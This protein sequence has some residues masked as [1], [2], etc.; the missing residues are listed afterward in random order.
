MDNV[1]ELYTRWSGIWEEYLRKINGN[2]PKQRQTKGVVTPPR[3][4]MATPFTSR[5]GLWHRK[6]ANFIVDLRKLRSMVATRFG[7]TTK[8]WNRV[9]RSSRAM[10]ERYGAPHLSEQHTE[11]PDELMMNILQESYDHYLNIWKAELRQK[12]HEKRVAFREQLAQHGGVNRLVSRLVKQSEVNYPVIKEGDNTISDPTEVVKRVQDAW[13]VYFNKKQEPLDEEWLE[14]QKQLVSNYP[15]QLPLLSAETLSDTIKQK[16]ASTSPGPDGWHMEEL[17]ALPLSSLEGLAYVLRRAEAQGR[18]PQAATDAWMA[19][20]PKGVE[21]SPPI[22]VRPITILSTVYR[23]YASTRAA[24]LQQWAQLAYHEWQYAFIKG[25]SARKQLSKLGL[26]LDEAVANNQPALAVSLDAS[27]AFPSIDR[28]QAAVLLSHAGFPVEIIRIVESLYDQ[29]TVRMRYAGAVV[30]EHG[31]HLR[32]GVHQG[33]PISVL[34]FNMIL[35]PLCR[36]LQ[37]EGLVRMAIVFADDVSIL[38]D[39][40]EKM[41]ASLDIILDY[42]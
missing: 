4:Q 30:P 3:T 14:K 5:M 34:C 23:V 33:C 28:R 37:D 9:A 36:R 6:L 1:D 32:Q 24:Q 15:V 27:K 18:L 31:F 16:S 7:D 21:P 42:L 17:Q 39:S 20:I 10:A 11:Q 19:L 25:R 13:Q 29:G 38:T 2:E 35:A 41:E 8:L 26:A 40:Q 12:R 22:G